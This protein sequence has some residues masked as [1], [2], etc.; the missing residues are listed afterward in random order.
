[1]CPAARIPYLPHVQNAKTY[2]LK[3]K[4]VM[5]SSF[6]Y[7]TNQ[8]TVADAERLLA[9]KPSPYEDPGVMEEFPVVDSDSRMV[10]LGTASRRSIQNFVDR[11]YAEHAGGV[12]HAA[13]YAE[14][15]PTVPLPHNGV[16]ATSLLESK[17]AEQ[18]EVDM[19]ELVPTPGTGGSGG[20]GDSADV[21]G[22]RVVETPHPPGSTP[23]ERA[24]ALPA[25]IATPTPPARVPVAQQRL[26]FDVR[27]YTGGVYTPEYLVE[28][29]QKQKMYGDHSERRLPL[30]DVTGRFITVDPAPFQVPDLTSLTLLHYLFA[31]MMYSRIYVTQ[32]GRLV[33][34][35]YKG[36]FRDEK[37]L[38]DRYR[39]PA[40]FA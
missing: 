7:L 25:R 12:L 34:V 29:A 24:L 36:D 13:H 3:A 17:V 37:W 14:A 31:T 28:A 2:T 21:E 10:L 26:M 5:H 16:S 20:L 40:D 33:G 22:Q 9:K 30:F 6:S 8:S 18:E 1:M 38:D 19:R 15:T 32:H 39:D 23:S 11:A 4:D 27:V 35:V